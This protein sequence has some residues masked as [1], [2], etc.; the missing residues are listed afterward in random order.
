MTTTHKEIAKRLEGE[1]TAAE[2]GQLLVQVQNA[3]TDLEIAM[4]PLHPGDMSHRRGE[5]RMRVL[6]SGTPEDLLNMR[7]KFDVMQAQ[8]DQLKAQVEELN[9]RRKAAAEQEAFKGLPALQEKLREKIAAAE[10]AQRALEA[11]FDAIDATYLEIVQAHATCNAGGLRG[12]A[13]TTVDTIDRLA[14]LTPFSA[15]RRHFALRDPNLHAQALGL[16]PS[17][18]DQQKAA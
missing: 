18:A 10:E 15:Q 4:A 3:L 1:L 17:T 13:G 7:D 12:A 8:W 9:R 11:A 2:C 6:L 16:E 5:E 14:R